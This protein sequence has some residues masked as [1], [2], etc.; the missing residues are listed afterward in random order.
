[1]ISGEESNRFLNDVQN[2]KQINTSELYKLNIE[3]ISQYRRQATY[4]NTIF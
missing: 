4:S 3:I 2:L 1:M